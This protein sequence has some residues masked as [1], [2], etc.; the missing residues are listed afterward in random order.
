MY[1]KRYEKVHFSA[2]T[3]L[4]TPPNPWPNETMMM[5]IHISLQHVEDV[6]MYMYTSTYSM[7]VE[8]EGTLEVLEAELADI[9]LRQVG[10]VRRVGG[11]VPCLDLVRSK[12]YHF[13]VIVHRRLGGWLPAQQFLLA[14]AAA[15]LSSCHLYLCLCLSFPPFCSFFLSP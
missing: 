5:Y 3:S 1:G 9:E 8:C 12:L 4:P 11:G 2:S 7:L 14:D 13:E 6:H 15:A 10:V